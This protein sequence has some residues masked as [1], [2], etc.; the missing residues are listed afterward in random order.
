MPD[1]SFTMEYMKK[2]VYALIMS[3]LICGGCMQ[4]TEII[5]SGDSEAVIWCATDIHYLSET[6]YDRGKAFQRLLKNNDGKLFEY[7]RE[8]M[9]EMTK[10]VIE[11]KPET[12][13]MLGDLTFNGEMESLQEL[14]GYFQR[15]E[16]A[17]VPVIVI[18][19]NHD[20]SY[21]Y[22]NAYFGDIAKSV[23]AVTSVQFRQEMQDF[24]YGESIA[25]DPDSCSYVYALRDDLWILTLDANT[26]AAPCAL[27]DSTKQWLKKQLAEAAEKQI[28]VMTISHQNVLK[29]NDMMY[30][31]Y[32]MND[33]EEVQQILKDG[34]VFLHLSG[35]SHLQHT[36]VSEG[37]TDICNEALSV[38][39]LSYGVITLKPG[40]TDFSYEKKSL[41]ILQEES[42][43]RFDETILRTAVPT[44]EE[45]DIPQEIREQMTD[46]AVRF[47]EIFYTG[48]EADPDELR[49]DPAY[50]YWRQYAG[51][52]FWYL[53]MLNALK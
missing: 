51:D 13:V 43:E 21:P 8:I 29:Q 40:Q 23:P 49:S 7:D 46:F 35:H 34:G 22:A 52:S 26:E 20:I 11:G 15:M 37:L 32:V 12:F 31:G 27:Q 2:R 39:P 6:L 44:L 28:T 24:G 47:N 30:M 1:D 17:G 5:R 19:G 50:G 41:G 45:I 33:Y 53:Y 38:W 16:E 36:S 14:K 4:Q 9:E 3:A 42:R 18:P 10:Q 48:A 25:K